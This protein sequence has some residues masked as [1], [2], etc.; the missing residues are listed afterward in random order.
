[1]S[2]EQ[3]Q[4]ERWNGYDEFEMTCDCCGN[5][6]TFTDM[7]FYQMIEEAKSYGWVMFKEDGE[8]MHNCAGCAGGQ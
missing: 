6:Q 8:W 4:K 7:D 3:L 1:M 5:S 2:I